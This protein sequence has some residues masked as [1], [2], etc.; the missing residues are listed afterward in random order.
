MNYVIHQQKMEQAVRYL[1]EGDIDLWLILTSEGSDP[2]LPL[3][4]GVKSVG[5]AAFLICKDGKKYAMCSRID[6]QDIEESGLFDEVLKYSTELGETLREFVTQHQP[7]TIALNYSRK[8]NLADGLTTGRYRWLR[9]VLKDCYS[10]E[11]TSSERFLEKLRS[12]KTPLEIERIK[13][14]IVVTQEIYDEIFTQLRAG[15]SEIEIGQLFVKEME[16]REVVNGVDRTLSMPIVMK[17]RIAH[18]PPGEAIVAPGDLVIMDFSVDVEG[19]VSD[20]A[21]TV[22]FLK[23]GE[24]K[25]PAHIQA[26]FDAAHAAI[27]AAGEALKPGVQGYEVDLVARNLLLDRGMP[28]ITHATGHQIGRDVHDGGT[29]LGPRWERYGH[30]PYGLVEPGMVFTLEPTILPED[31]PTFIVEENVLVTEAG[32]EYLTERQDELILIP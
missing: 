1:Q 14:A 5:P 22:Y 16:K 32:I 21:R 30:A 8:E 17:E 13:Q 31:G 15:M 3:I 19:Y 29:L 23:P 2:C 20:I 26:A 25:A 27:T 18:R 6:A 7:K 24:T 11:F 10:G 12:I 9:N 28:E 4:T